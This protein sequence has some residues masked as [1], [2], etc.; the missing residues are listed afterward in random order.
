MTA[1]DRFATV[2]TAAALLGGGWI[3][4]ASSEVRQPNLA[5]AAA[6][7]P[8]AA[9]PA[10]GLL[11]P[12]EGIDAAELTDTFTQSRE[13]GARLHDAIDIAA[14]EGTRVLA[15]APGRVE[16]L[17]L[18]EEGGLTVYVRSSDGRTQHYYAHLR[19]YAPALAE[20]EMLRRGDPVGEVGSTGNAEPANPHLH[21]AIYRTD[22][23]A[24]WHAEGE[25][26]NPYPL[27]SGG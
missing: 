18:S 7:A 20:G 26:V 5:G 11:V 8:A 13:G 24:P 17:F 9:L 21:F 22:P 16:K 4:F 3:V 14:P 12:V 2:L 15:A 23:Q 6:P 19:R 25:P 1:L 27:L 10:D